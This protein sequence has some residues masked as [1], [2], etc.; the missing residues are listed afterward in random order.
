MHF[1]CRKNSRS[2]RE[3]IIVKMHVLLTENNSALIT[4]DSTLRCFNLASVSRTWGAFVLA[5][6]VQCSLITY[7]DLITYYALYACVLRGEHT[8]GLCVG[9]DQHFHT[10]EGF[11]GHT[12]YVPFLQFWENAI[13]VFITS[14]DCCNAISEPI[15]IKFAHNVNVA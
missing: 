2:K 14:F 12:D 7:T 9:F 4:D 15:F 8:L 5:K 10:F 13:K 11:R 6:G 1:M 3:I